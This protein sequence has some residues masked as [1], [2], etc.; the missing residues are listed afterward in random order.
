VGIPDI[1]ALTV[2]GIPDKT[3]LI[4]VGYTGNNS[5]DGGG[6]KRIQQRLQWWGISDTTALL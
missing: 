2:V 3:A 5:A 4:V 6:V 1:A